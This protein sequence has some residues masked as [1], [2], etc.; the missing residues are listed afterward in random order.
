VPR[1][2]DARQNSR[3]HDRNGYRMT[4]TKIQLFD[5]PASTG[6]LEPGTELFPAHLRK[7]GL[8][9]RLAESGIEIVDHGQVPFSDL[10][11]H[12]T[13]PI[14]NYPAPRRVWEATESF[15]ASHL[16]AKDGLIFA[17]GG[18]CSIV[19]GTVSGLQ[20]ILGKKIHLLYLDG[21]VDSLAPDPAKCVGSAGMGLWLLTQESEFW[22]RNRLSPSQITVIGNKA[23]PATG[24]GIPFLSL[25]Y[26][27]ERGL[28]DAMEEVLAAIPEDAHILVHFDVDVLREAEMPAAYAPRPEGLSMNDVA[29][30][31]NRIF[32]DKRVAYFEITEF[33]P[34]KDPRGQYVTALIQTIVQSLSSSRQLNQP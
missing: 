28:Q 21:D 29:I 33:V 23:P 1:E 10:E 9:K 11:R 14:R 8:V 4:E 31:L 26:V 5:I 2:L 17:L 19:V 25:Q 30:L 22:K 13:P 27:S 32:S 34:Q 20:N 18:D 24:V 16:H 15:I 7:H 12:N 6:C 3:C